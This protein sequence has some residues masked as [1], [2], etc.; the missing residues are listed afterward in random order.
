M[1]RDRQHVSSRQEPAVAPGTQTMSASDVEFLLGNLPQRWI[2]LVMDK[3]RAKELGV[4][5]VQ[6]LASTTTNAAVRAL[7][8]LQQGGSSIRNPNNYL[9]SVCKNEGDRHLSGLWA[10]L[11]AAGV[12]EQQQQVLKDFVA[13]K[14]RSQELDSD[15]ISALMGAPAEVASSTLREARKKSDM[16][17]LAEFVLTSCAKSA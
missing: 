9:K 16:H 10:K 17:N 14:V 4:E 7:E 5:A 6:A 1:S 12:N 3:Y 13:D 8:C 11:K 2:D 15:A